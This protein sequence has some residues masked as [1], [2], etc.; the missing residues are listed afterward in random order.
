MKLSHIIT[1]GV[2]ILIINAGI[3]LILINQ[4]RPRPAPIPTIFNDPDTP[5]DSTGISRQN[6]ITRA[7][8]EVAPAVVSVNVIKTQI[9]RG[10]IPSN[11]G[12]FG[13][14]DF[15]GPV[16]RQVQ[17]IGSGVIYDPEGYVITNAH[18]VKGAADIKIVLPD[19]REFDAELIGID[20]IHDI[21][22]LRIRSS[23]LPVARLGNSDNLMVGEWSIALGN[24]YGY[25]MNDSQPSVTVGVISALGRNISQDQGGSQYLNMIQTDTAINQGN[26]GGPLV[27]I[28]GEVIGINTFIFS[29]TGGSIG[30]GFAI[31]INTVKDL[32]AAL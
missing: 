10:R 21:A 23:Q 1:L 19:Q 17:S 13:F 32:M 7:V 14:F 4:F 11:F 6:A 8:A 27:N 26:S 3:S 30:L 9:V 20:D 29:E 25:L 24:P 18:V 28:Q 5:C 16:R 15:F 31:P 22:K 2:I 12:F